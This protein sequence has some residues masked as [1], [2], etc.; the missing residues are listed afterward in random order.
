MVRSAHIATVGALAVAVFAITRGPVSELASQV[1]KISMLLLAA[2]FAN[3]AC[4][5]SARAPSG[6]D[7]NRG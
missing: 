1:S 4:S 6:R 7:T 5:L 2:I 3:Q